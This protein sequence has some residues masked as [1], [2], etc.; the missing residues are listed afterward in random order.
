VIPLAAAGALVVAA[1]LLLA[2]RPFPAGGPP[3]GNGN[4]DGDD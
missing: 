1:F 3:G 4:G 2:W